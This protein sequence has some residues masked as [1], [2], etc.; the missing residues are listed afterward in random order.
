M[1]T[2]FTS[3]FLGWYNLSSTKWFAIS[4]QHIGICMTLVLCYLTRLFDVLIFKWRNSLTKTESSDGKWQKSAR[5]FYYRGIVKFSCNCNVN[6][7]IIT[8]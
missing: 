4:M 8:M 6:G 3:V 7:A 2:F 5:Q 1:S